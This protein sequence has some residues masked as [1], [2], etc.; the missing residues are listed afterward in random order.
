MHK[1][2]NLAQWA[3]EPQST[4]LDSVGMYVVS[5]AG[6]RVQDGELAP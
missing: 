2:P 3:G 1:F 4:F 6:N 5:S